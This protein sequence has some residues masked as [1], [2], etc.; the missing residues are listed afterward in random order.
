MTHT[1]TVYV[2]DD[3]PVMRRHLR[4]ILE[5]DGL[6][7]ETFTSA[8]DFLVR[9]DPARPGCVVLDVCMPGMDGLE[10]QRRL[11]A[12]PR[13]FPVVMLSAQAD[14]PTAV[15]AMHQGAVYFLE[16]PTTPDLLVGYVRA[17]L[18]RC[19]SVA[20]GDDERPAI[21]ARMALLTSRE[22]EVLD[23]LVDGRSVKEVARLLGTSPNTVR[24]QRAG[25]QQKL[26]ADSVADLVRMAM[27]VRLGPQMPD[28][29]PA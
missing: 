22:R 24:N 21:R 14:V 28:S 20:G 4:G 9:H 6:P 5:A 25:I 18:A 1:A 29:P 7:V 12:L 11:A 19:A 26:H 13:P 3:D 8:E 27:L 15:R 16:K 2:V 23:L 17:A 10:L